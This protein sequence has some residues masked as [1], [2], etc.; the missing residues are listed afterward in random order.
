MDAF[1]VIILGV[2][3]G[4]TEFLPVSSSG[5]LV[6]VEALMGLIDSDQHGSQMLLI[7]VVLHGGTLGAIL[8]VYWNRIW[9][10]LGEDRGVIPRIVVGTLPAVVVALGLKWFVPALVESPL[11]AGGMLIVTAAML[12]FGASRPE[13]GLNYQQ[14]SYKA[15]FTIGCFQAVAVLPGISRSGATI[16][17]GLL[18]G[19]RRDSAATFSFLLALPVIAG[20]C[21]LELADLGSQQPDAS[22]LGLLALGAAT[23]FFVGWFALRWLLAWL[24]RGRLYLFALWC[25]PVGLGVVVWQLVLRF[26]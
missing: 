5:H 19:L 1:Q 14:L 13:G 15:A 16:V 17:A 25:A 6:I 20:A 2:I 21:V 26:G 10:L 7:N 12:W 11:L 9:R 8:V 18:V 22:M 23:S 24:Q 4:L 3:Q